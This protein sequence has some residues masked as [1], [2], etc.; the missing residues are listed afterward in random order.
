M[1]IVKKT[2]SVMDERQL[3]IVSSTTLTIMPAIM[4]TIVESPHESWFATFAKLGVKGWLILPIFGVV[5][6]TGATI[7][8][9]LA[10]R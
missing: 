6:Y 8:Q 5:I 1:L 10:I 4:S 7:L 9:Q 2:N 3:L